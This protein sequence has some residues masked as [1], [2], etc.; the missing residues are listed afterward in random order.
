[1]NS[2]TN[3]NEG[4][5]GFHEFIDDKKSSALKKYQALVIGSQSFS[6]LIKFELFTFFLMNM[7]GML[8]LFLRQTLYKS[9][10]NKCGGK[11]TFGTGISLKQPNKVTIGK[12]CI[13]DDMVSVSVR[14]SNTSSITLEDNVFVGRGS[15]LKVREGTINIDSF[16]SIGSNCRISTAEGNIKIGKYVFLAAFCYIGGGNHKSD[17]TDIPIAKQG[18]ESK[19]GVTI[20]DDVWLGANC[21]V[22]DGVTIG[23]GSIIG[24]SSLVNKDIPEYSIA[25]GLPAKVYKSRLNSSAS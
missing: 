19:G 25:F 23:K 12:N 13:I 4:A 6:A 20:G 9:L 18:F 7:P 22:A 1:M 3:K 14:G 5:L 17:R 8:G 16:S 21:V 2:S 15:E 10:F 24:A 11:V